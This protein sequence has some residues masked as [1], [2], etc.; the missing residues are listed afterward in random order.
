MNAT[1][2]AARVR[3]C[4]LVGAHHDHLKHYTAEL[5]RQVRRRTAELA[6]SRLDLIHCLARA[7]EYRDRET[8]HHVVR[9]GCYAGM[10]ARKLGLTDSMI[11]LIEHAAPL[12]DMGKIGIPDAILLKPGK[13]TPDEYDAM[14]RHVVFGKRTFEPMSNEE[15][16]TYKTHTSLGE[17]IMGAERSP[18]ISMASKIALT[19][20]E[21]WDGSG[22]PLGLSGEDIPLGGRITAVADVF[23]AL[24][25]RR[26]YKSEWPIDRCFAALEEGRGTQF[27]PAV[28]DALLAC[29]QEVIQVR[30]R[31]ADL[32]VK[33]GRAIG[34]PLYRR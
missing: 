20:H 24:S 23:D 8:G 31:F 13:L 4:L 28:V 30:M 16:R 7:A 15:W 32:E 19:H 6:A 25:S 34:T 21:K 10:I 22:Y 29:R 5:E 2:L 14:K 27:D 1:E 18:L 26:P 12:H 17:S 33:P 9:V 3:N 11:E